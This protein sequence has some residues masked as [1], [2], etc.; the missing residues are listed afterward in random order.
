MRNILSWEQFNEGKKPCKE[1]GEIECCCEDGDC[2]TDKKI[3]KKCKK[4]KCVCRK[5]TKID[6]KKKV[7]KKV[8][9]KKEE[10]KPAAKKGLTAA[11]KKL[12]EGLKK[13]ILKKQGK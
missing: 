5:T 8:E 4:Q 2:K 3:C 7:E 11:Q 9:D 13:A 1:C 6:E 10:K 12:P